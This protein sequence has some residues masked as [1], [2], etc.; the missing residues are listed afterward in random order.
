MAAGG[1][2]L[3]AVG[4][5][6]SLFGGMKAAKAEKKAEKLRERQMELEGLRKK[7]ENLRQS[8]IQKA[9]ITSNAVSSGAGDSS[10]LEGGVAGVTGQANRQNLA[11]NQDLEIGHGIFKQNAKAAKGRSIAAIGEGISSF[12]SLFGSSGGTTFKLG[13]Y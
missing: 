6:F 9:E 10:A 2:I 7:R 3:G 11:V 13:S 12:G 5:A 1:L 4:Q 8:F